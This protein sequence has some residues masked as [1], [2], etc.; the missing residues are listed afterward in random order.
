MVLTG[1]ASTVELSED[2]LRRLYKQRSNIVQISAPLPIMAESHHRG[3]R[4]PSSAS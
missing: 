3:H 4:A 2:G 1:Q